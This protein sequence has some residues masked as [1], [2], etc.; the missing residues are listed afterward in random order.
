MARAVAVPLA[1]GNP[2]RDNTGHMEITRL[3][4]ITDTAGLLSDPASEVPKPADDGVKECECNDAV[5]V[6]DTAEVDDIFPMVPAVS[7][8]GSTS[9]SSSVVIMPDGEDEDSSSLEN[10]QI[11]ESSCSLSVASDTSS[12]AAAEEL[13]GLEGA[14][15][16]S[17]PTSAD[18]EKSL[19]GVRI[20]PPG[21]S[22]EPGGDALLDPIYDLITGPVPISRA[23]VEATIEGSGCDSKASSL[24]LQMAREKRTD[25]VLGSRRV[26]E[27]DCLPLWGS[28]SM[29]GRRPEME[30]AVAVEPRFLKIPLRLLVGDG[31]VDGM[32]QHLSLSTAHFFG[33]YD[34]HGGAQ[35]ANYCRERVHLALVEEVENLQDGEGCGS[36]DWHSQWEKAFTNCFLKV[37]AEVG[38]RVGRG[39]VGSK[40]D[41]S[42]ERLEPIAPET[43]G[44]TAV[45]A[46]VCASHIIVA[47]CGDSRAVLC[48]GKEPLPLSV[49]HKPNREDEYERIEAAGGKVIQWNGH[50]VFGVLAMS[51]SI[52]VHVIIIQPQLMNR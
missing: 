28:V 21:N 46:V 29:C 16:L 25:G 33:V 35:V 51:R 19:G 31:A 45:V 32:D 37:D 30:D 17:T 36:S 13:F 9:N 49:D 47:N 11:L 48:R 3:K 24:I 8:V 43:V 22:V 44:S 50:R 5:A 41:A 20:L 42:E 23:P 14:F 39:G 15:E 38:G 7:W 27:L 4:L 18:I 34:G 2:I 6:P 40:G 12:I 26:L 1:I 52:V 10:E